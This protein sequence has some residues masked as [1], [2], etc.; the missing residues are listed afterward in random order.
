MKQCQFIGKFKRPTQKILAIFLTLLFILSIDYYVFAQRS[1]G[2][3]GSRGGR[4]SVRH[5]RVANHGHDRDRYKQN[6]RHRRHHRR[7]HHG[8]VHYSTSYNY[9]DDYNKTSCNE[10]GRN[11]VYDYYYERC[12]CD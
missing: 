6:Q 9:D 1:R 5:H 3:G 10:Y 11:C 4:G 2:G 7:H 12:D 8:S